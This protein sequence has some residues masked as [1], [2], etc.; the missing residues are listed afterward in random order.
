MSFDIQLKTKKQTNSIIILKK[1]IENDYYL[2][3]RKHQRLD[4]ATMLSWYSN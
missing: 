4:T 2:F 3:K 1:F